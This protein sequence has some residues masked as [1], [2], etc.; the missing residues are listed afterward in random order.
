MTADNATPRDPETIAIE[1]LGF[2]A[3]D[4]ELLHR[5]FAVSGLQAI[6]LRH[7]SVEP[8]FLGGVLEFILAHEPT[9]LRFAEATGIDPAAIAKA[10]RALPLGDE[11]H[12]T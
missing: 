3:Q 12:E 8:G 2:I 1:A 9:L 6:T 10:R 11:P 4:H 7:A 5:F